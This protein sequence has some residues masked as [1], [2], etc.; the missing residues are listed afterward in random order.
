MGK[1]VVEFSNSRAESL[2]SEQSQN[3]AISQNGPGVESPPIRPILSGAPK[4]IHQ[5]S[6][7]ASGMKLL[8]KNDEEVHGDLTDE[9]NN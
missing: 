9:E 1:V 4:Q 2:H 6:F 7:F 5:Q 3:E 8:V